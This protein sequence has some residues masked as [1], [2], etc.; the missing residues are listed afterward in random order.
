MGFFLIYSFFSVELGTATFFLLQIVKDCETEARYQDRIISKS[1]G[2]NEPIGNT[3]YNIIS[4]ITASAYWGR[5]NLNINRV[6]VPIHEWLH[7]QYGVPDLVSTF[8]RK[9]GLYVKMETRNLNT[10]SSMIRKAR[11]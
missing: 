7:S 9:G 10:V 2:M 6:G 4:F 5:C 1:W 11:T 8:F 3:G